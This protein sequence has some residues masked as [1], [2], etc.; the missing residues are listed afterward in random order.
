MKFACYWRFKVA[1]WNY[2]SNHLLSFREKVAT[3]A[4]A[5]LVGLGCKIERLHRETRVHPS[6]LGG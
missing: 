1:D 4:A 3:T 5:E 2:N 6:S